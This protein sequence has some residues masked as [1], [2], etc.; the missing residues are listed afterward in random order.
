MPTKTVKK[1][2]SLTAANLKSFLARA[3]EWVDTRLLLKL[4]ILPIEGTTIKD[5]RNIH[6]T[7]FLLLVLEEIPMRFPGG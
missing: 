3:N 5:F 7:R 4:V 1:T 2:H 6:I